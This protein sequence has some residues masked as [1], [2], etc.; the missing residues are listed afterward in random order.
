M[1]GKRPHVKI[2]S[3]SYFL[4]LTYTGTSI[5]SRRCRMFPLSPVLA[6]QLVGTVQC[7]ASPRQSCFVKCLCMATARAMLKS[8]PAVHS[9]AQSKSHENNFFCN[10]SF[11]H[12]PLFFLPSLRSVFYRTV[13]LFNIVI[14]GIPDAPCRGYMNSNS[15][16]HYYPR[17]YAKRSIQANRW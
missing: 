3:R 16:L 5:N 13:K 2:N 15:K 1:S 10:R 14:M 6:H 4:M 12:S 8:E 7:R 11:S 9:V 17:L